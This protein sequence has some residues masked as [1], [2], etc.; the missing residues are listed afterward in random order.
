MGGHPYK[1]IKKEEK[2]TKKN[3]N[4]SRWKNLFQLAE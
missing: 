1:N 3:E 2:K 4:N